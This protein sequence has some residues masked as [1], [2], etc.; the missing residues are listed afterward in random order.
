MERPI[1]TRAAALLL[2][3]L[4]LYLIAAVLS[5][6]FAL[7]LT[8]GEL[9]CPL[10]MLQRLAIALLAIGPILNLRYGPRPSHYGLSLLVGAAGALFAGRQ[11]LLHIVP[12]DPGYGSA[13]L[14]LHYYT[15][16]F[17]VF[18]LAIVAIGAML[19]LDSQFE[20]QAQPRQPALHE[21][22]AVW[23]VIAVTAANVFATVLECG[24]AACPDNPVRYELLHWG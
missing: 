19:M 15:W 3:T 9:P 24:F 1:D 22:H 12:P 11:V 5:A 2:N 10:C 14:G 16:A 6:A 18:A 21:H 23:L 20:T 13:V 17:I 8:L 7:Q 4:A